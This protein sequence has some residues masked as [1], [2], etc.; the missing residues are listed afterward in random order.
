MLVSLDAVVPGAFAD[1]YAIGAFNV[2]NIETAQAVLSAAEELKAPV[3]VQ[4]SEKAL[5]YAGFDNLTSVVLNM[6][7]QSTV[8]VV[9]HLDHGRSTDIAEKCLERGYSSVMVDFSHSSFAENLA[10][11]KSIVSLAKKHGASVEAELGAVLGREDYIEHKVASKTDPAEAAQ[12]VDEVHLSVLAVG[13]GNAH[14]IT[15]KEEK[16]DFDLLAQIQERT[17]FPLVLHGASGNSAKDI[18]K[19][20]ENGVVKINIDTDLRLAWSGAV[21][22]YLRSNPDAYDIR[23]INEAGRMAISMTVKQKIALFGSIGKA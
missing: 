22:K 18:H 1:H 14:G 10:K 23:D 12:F 7:K 11:T 4:T 6:A 17:K 8:P 9:V 13:I 15:T 5:D 20:I 2:T 16:L 21:R 3:I 19:A